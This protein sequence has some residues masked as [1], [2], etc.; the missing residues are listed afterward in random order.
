MSNTNESISWDNVTV[1][2]TVTTE[3]VD[4]SGSKQEEQ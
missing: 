4:V 1:S 2:D 3:K